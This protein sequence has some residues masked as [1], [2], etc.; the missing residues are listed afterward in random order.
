MPEGHPV[1]TNDLDLGFEQ[2][3]E[4]QLHAL[5]HLPREVQDVGAGG[6]AAVTSTRAWPS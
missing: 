1:S 2:D 6:A 4:A 5:L 3:A